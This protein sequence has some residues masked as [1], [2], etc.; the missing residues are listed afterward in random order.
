MTKIKINRSNYK[1]KAGERLLDVIN[2]VGKEDSTSLLPSS[3][4]AIQTCNTC[5]VEINRV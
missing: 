3:I 5:L 4:G 2:Q 1:A